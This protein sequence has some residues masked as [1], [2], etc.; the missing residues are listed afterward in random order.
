[1]SGLIGSS[2]SLG[3]GFV[4]TPNSRLTSITT[5]LLGLILLLAL[6]TG[7]GGGGG[8]NDK[9]ATP[10]STTITSQPV[11]LTKSSAA[12]F[13]FVSDDTAATFECQ[14]DGGNFEGCTTP[15]EYSGIIEGTHTFCVRAVGTSGTDP[16]P[17]C[18]TW[19][20]DTTTPVNTS[21]VNFIDGGNEKTNSTTV[22]L[23][24]SATDNVG[25]TAYFV[26]ENETGIPASQP[27]ADDP[28][29]IP[30]TSTTNFNADV[31]YTFKDIHFSDTKVH[32]YVFFKD[33][34][35]N[36]TAPVTSEFF[37]DFELGNLAN[38]TIGGRQTPPSINIAEVVVRN[39]SK[40]AHL[41]HDDFTEIT[42]E[43]TFPYDEK[44]NFMLQME[45]AV[46]SQASGT[47]DFYSLAGVVFDFLD[48]AGAI[49]GRVG[50]ARS[51]STYPFNVHCSLVF[52]DPQMCR[53]NRLT[54]SSVANH[55]LSM[56][57]L[58]GQITVS[59]PIDSIKLT[60]SAYASGWTYNMSADVWIDDFAVVNMSKG[61]D[62]IVYDTTP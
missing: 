33:G 12:S 30:T 54:G 57:D 43:K 36:V 49:I 29:W 41:R 15:K 51:T 44:M 14:M 56:P 18:A 26:A 37:D 53:L 23:H 28:A 17:P 6:L 24:L 46:S 10:P 8:G 31:S 39:N 35:G 7:C 21:S 62:R 1:M 20:V 9:G 13:A 61:W 4:M 32:L 5:A 11:D 34:A 38:W 48:G 42:L 22:M 59:K 27:A 45:T 50:Y 19:T 55:S 52:A 3:G 47:S 60:I 16:G 25:V 2:S 58:L 40:K